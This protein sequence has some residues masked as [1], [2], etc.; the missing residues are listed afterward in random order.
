MRGGRIEETTTNDSDG[1]A[2]SADIEEGGEGG[3]RP[4]VLP[5]IDAAASFDDD[6]IEE[7]GN[8]REAEN[9]IEGPEEER[10]FAPSES[11]SSGPP[12]TAPEM[13]I[14]ATRDTMETDPAILFLPS[15]GH[16]AQR[17]ATTT[18][19]WQ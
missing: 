16:W 3:D 19:R 1:A 10:G 8:D 17:E 4:A 12:S 2:G 5:G 11:G 9:S 6:V 15:P 13:L 18:L 7:Q 14:G